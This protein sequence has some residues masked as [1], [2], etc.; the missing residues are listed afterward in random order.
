MSRGAW[1]AV[2]LVRARGLAA[3][4]IA[5]ALSLA[6]GGWVWTSGGPATVRDHY[7]AAAP[8]LSLVGQTLV[9]VTPAGDFIPWAVA[10]GAAFGVALGALLNWLAWMGACAVLFALA[11]WSSV[12]LD[13]DAELHRL[14]RWLA[15]LPV[16]HALFLIGARWVPLGGYLAS[17]AAGVLRVP[18][19]R[20]LWCTAVGSAPQALLLSLV[21]AGLVRTLP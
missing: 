13:L 11:R 4:G 17:V 5:C 14:P 1:T 2:A 8:A 3:S 18:F 19:G 12:D 15:R 10:N 6:V 20:L 7:G 16:H 21:G 9:A